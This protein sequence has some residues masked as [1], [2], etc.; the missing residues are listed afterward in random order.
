[1]N[2]KR[3]L[4]VR[5]VDSI[6]QAIRTYAQLHGIQMGN[7]VE[8]LITQGLEQEGYSIADMIQGFG[9]ISK[10]KT[11]YDKTMADL[12]KAFAV[13][14]KGHLD[15]EKWEL[16]GIPGGIQDEGEPSV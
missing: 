16:K 8:I 9:M 4:A 1:M 14:S 13:D 2:N 11:G 5:V 12:R 3:M 10:A 6:D 15:P 7:A